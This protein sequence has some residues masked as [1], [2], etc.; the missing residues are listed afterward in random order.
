MA[1][2]A[3]AARLGAAQQL[4][5]RML[6]RRPPAW[7]EVFRGIAKGYQ[8]FTPLSLSGWELFTTGVDGDNPVVFMEIEVE[9]RHSEHI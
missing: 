9:H 1:G 7:R 2:V 3:K 4:G 6:K 8:C 5:P